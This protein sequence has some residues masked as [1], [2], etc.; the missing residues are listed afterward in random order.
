VERAK[1][2]VDL[3][4]ANPGAGTLGLDGEMIDRPHL[5]QARRILGLAAAI[6]EKQ[7]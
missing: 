4:D 3:F 6:E 7:G 1:R 5:I 2:I